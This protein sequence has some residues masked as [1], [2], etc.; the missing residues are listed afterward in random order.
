MRNARALAERLAETLSDAL[1]RAA[2]IVLDAIRP[3]PQAK[4]VP[5]RVRSRRP[6]DG[7]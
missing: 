2:E 4:L 6:S 7:R 3:Q 1:V 5:V